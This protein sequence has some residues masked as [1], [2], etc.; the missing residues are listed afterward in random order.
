MSGAGVEKSVVFTNLPEDIT[1]LTFAQLDGMNL[2]SNYPISDVFV[3]VK[4][5][6]GTVLKENV[7][8]SM[9]AVIREV[10]MQSNNSTWTKDENGNYLTMTAGMQELAT[11]ENTVEIRVQ[12]AT[13]EK[14]TVFSGTLNP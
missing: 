8:R 12:L 6:D 13:G 7:Y 3:T 5:A 2:G 4:S 11:G 9:Y 1:S 14:P 10:S